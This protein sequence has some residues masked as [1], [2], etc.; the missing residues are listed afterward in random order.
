[1]GE[2]VARGVTV[3]LD[4]GARMRDGTT[5]R[6]NVY[7]PDGDGPWPTLLARTPY[8]KIDPDIL[9]WLEPVNAARQ[10]FMVVIQDTR[11]RFASEGEWAPFR[12]ERQDGY[13]TVE[14]AARLPGSNGRVGMFGD[15]YVGH[16]QWL[17]AMERPPALAAIAPANTWCEPLD[18]VL[19]RG[20]A[21]ELG[22]GLFWTL[23]TG[24]A[25]VEKLS[26][27]DA[28]RDR[29]LAT[30]LDDYDRLPAAGYWD[31]PVDDMAV[32]ARTGMPDFGTFSMLADA[33][34]ADLGR[35]AGLHE[36]VDVPIFHTA[37]WHDVFLQGALD[38]HAAMTALGRPSR[39]VV[40]PW[41]HMTFA[42]PIGDLSFGI[43]AGR[44]GADAHEHGDHNDEQLA[45]LRHQLERVQGEEAAVGPKPEAGVSGAPV[46]IFVMGR[47]VWRDEAEWPPAR[48]QAE[49]WHLGAGGALAPGAPAPDGP[50][51]EFVYDPADPVPTVGGPTLLAT[52][53]RAGP[54]DQ[55][56]VEARADV[57]VF[58]SE[59]LREDLE[60]TGRVRV[61]L[62][63]ESSAPATDW[64]ARLCDVHPDGRSYNVC[65][66]IV[67]IAEGADR[68]G[69][70]EIDLWSTSNVFLAGH[71]LRVQVT[72]S[73]F[74]RWDR[75]LNTGD[76]RTPRWQTA[77]QRI[78][79]TGEYASWIEL[80]VIA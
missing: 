75:N 33:G 21:L 57:C 51:T 56:R 50:P 3:E 76:Q 62:H 74:P 1:L 46:R 41:T 80:P 17:A 2:A 8:G 20:G 38:N 65:D 59:R 29:R 26:L 19:A 14:W 4:V 39:I 18:G 49:H 16:V 58:T 28:E 77:R 15:S 64:V 22:F 48:A 52:A 13:D 11:G 45:W 78:H 36:R 5:L 66:G 72:S 53:F 31:L 23:I 32:V 68:R 67:R 35:V 6:A 55:A 63:A 27:P 34:A 54:L 47:N 30:L 37:G 70:V 42:D 25:Q 71:R 43:R 12:F 44:L 7:R 73:C 69:R 10:G 61:V 24:A 79:H 40:G 9:S 60:V